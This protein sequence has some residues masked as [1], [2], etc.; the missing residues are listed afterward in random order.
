MCYLK[1]SSS[2]TK[3]VKL[4]LIWALVRAASF[5]RSHDALHEEAARL[6]S[7]GPA[8]KPWTRITIQTHASVRKPAKF[9][10]KKKKK[11][12][13]FAATRSESLMKTLMKSELW[14]LCTCS[15]SHCYSAPS[16]TPCS[17]VISVSQVH[18]YICTP[19]KGGVGKMWRRSTSS[20]LHLSY[21]LWRPL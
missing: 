21:I 1:T 19:V 11:N 20:Y 17:N 7:A 12:Q 13:H 10:S 8:D 5:F 18:I 15:G 2:L 3:S 4:L 16:L 9:K 6:F 14:P